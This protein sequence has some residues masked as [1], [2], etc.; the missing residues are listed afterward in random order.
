MASQRLS[1]V[2]VA[3]WFSIEVLDGAFSARGWAE[4][5]GDALTQAALLENASDWS[6]EHRS[7]GSV[8][9]VELPDADAW[10][11]F[12]E[13]PLVRGA[14][15]AVPDPVN[16]LIFYRGRGGGSASGLPRRPRPMTGAG[17][18]ALPLPRSEEWLTT[19][20]LPAWLSCESG[21]G[22]AIGARA[23]RRTRT[24]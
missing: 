23:E 21:V 1:L 17:A 8:F 13:R 5:Y 12:Q 6:W 22:A 7:W 19:A 9:Q 2:D 20:W 15:D 3:E 10:T 4:A 24:N 14:L 18:C 11:R 16:G